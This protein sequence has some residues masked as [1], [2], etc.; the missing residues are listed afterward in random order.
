M[1]QSREY[2]A[3]ARYYGRR[4][5][6]RSGVPLIRHIDH[7][8]AILNAIGAS[9]RARRAFCLHPLV[10]ADADLA[11][12]YPRLA[13]LTDDPRVIVLALEYRSIANA[14]LSTRRIAKA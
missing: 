3:I 14:T 11:A 13:T 8:L 2:R 6:E 4:T 12:A 10:Q 1:T 9:Q 7:G 5:A